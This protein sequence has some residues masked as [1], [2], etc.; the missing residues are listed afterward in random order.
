MKGFNILNGSEYSD[1][2]KLKNLLNTKKSLLRSSH[3]GNFDCITTFL[4]KSNFKILLHEYL[5]QNDNNY[6]PTYIKKRDYIKKIINKDENTNKISLYLFTDSQVTPLHYHYKQLNKKYNNIIL[7]SDFY[8]TNEYLLK[9]ILNTW[10]KKYPSIFYTFVDQFGNEFFY[11]NFNNT[12]QFYI[13]QNGEKIFIKYKDITNIVVNFLKETS[14]SI[15]TGKPFKSRGFIIGTEM[16]IILSTLIDLSH[17]N[18]MPTKTSVYHISGLKMFNYLIKENNTMPHK[19]N[20][21]YNLLSQENKDIPKTINFYI[22]PTDNIKNNLVIMNN[23]KQIIYECKK[24]NLFKDNVFTQYDDI[25]N[26]YT[27]T[28]KTK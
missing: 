19:I 15:K 2:A 5:H 8:L 25:E 16:N 6:N 14:I 7:L 28:L 23:K 10:V 18:D 13:N 17:Q 24:A 12:G 26:K 22:I 27:I 11:D 4:A 21:L 20:F 1:F 3:V 9:K